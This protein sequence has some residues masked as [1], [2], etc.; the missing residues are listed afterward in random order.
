M[1]VKLS[2]IIAKINEKG[3]D[4][5]IQLKGRKRKYFDYNKEGMTEPKEI[6]N[7][8]FFVE[9]NLSASNIIQVCVKLIN[10]FGYS[11]D[12]I[13]IELADEKS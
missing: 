4:K 3:F 9:T 1:L 7:T 5:V 6:K 12:D 13:K 8:A 11:E 2:E 10:L